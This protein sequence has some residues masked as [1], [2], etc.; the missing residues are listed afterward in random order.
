MQKWARLKREQYGSRPLLHGQYF[1]APII[2][3]IEGDPIYY[4]AED[5]YKI[6]DYKIGYEY[7]PEYTTLLPRMYSSSPSHERKYMEV[8]GLRPGEKPT[9]SDN[10]RFMFLHQIGHMYLRYF[11]FNFAGRESDIQNASWLKPFETDKNVPE[12]IANNK[13]KYFVHMFQ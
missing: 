5:K 2:D 7:D 13:A 11:M 12:T 1:N 4:K 10:L 3:Y 8:T 9:F 6:A